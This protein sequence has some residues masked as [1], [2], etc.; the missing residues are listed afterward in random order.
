M[1]WK[2]RNPD[3][4]KSLKHV[5]KLFPHPLDDFAHTP[6]SPPKCHVMRQKQ[7]ICFC[8]W[9][10]PIAPLG[11]GPGCGSPGL[12]PRV[13]V[14]T[15]VRVPRPGSRGQPPRVGLG[16]QDTWSRVRGP[17]RPGSK[18]GTGPCKHKY[19][20]VRKVL[21]N[22]SILSRVVFRSNK[23]AGFDGFELPL[24]GVNF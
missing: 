6:S 19:T 9:N 7:N 15:E 16:P 4:L 22:I 23:T 3:L 2:S 13:R 10:F 12:A 11:P 5:G 18:I 17:N 24:L 8:C 14:P 21:A 1:I 20:Y